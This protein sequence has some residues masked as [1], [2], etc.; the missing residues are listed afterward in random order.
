[1][2][3]TAKPLAAFANYANDARAYLGLIG[4]DLTSFIADCTVSIYCQNDFYESRYDGFAIVLEVYLEQTKVTNPSD[5]QT[6]LTFCM[7]NK[8]DNYSCIFFSIHEF[9]DKYYEL[10]RTIHYVEEDADI[11]TNNPN[12]LFGDIAFD[13]SDGAG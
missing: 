11:I 12:G 5:M 6:A 13:N 2:V 1:L 4:L 7:E 10:T 8:T 3:I 9:S